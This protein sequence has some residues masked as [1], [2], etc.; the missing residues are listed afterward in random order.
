MDSCAG[1]QK[2]DPIQ[3]LGSLK[4]YL[5]CFSCS[6][7]FFYE[8]IQM[9]M[10][11]AINESL[12]TVFATDASQLS[13]LSSTY[14]WGDLAFLLPAGIILDKYST[15]HTVIYSM[16]LCIISTFGFAMTS[17]FWLA[18]FFHFLTG[19]GNAFCFLACVILVARWFPSNKQAMMIGLV[20]TIAFLGGMTAQ[21]PLTSLAAKFGWRKAL[22]VDGVFGMLVLMQIMMFV[23]DS[24]QSYIYRNN[25]PHHSV[26]QELKQVVRNK[27][28][29][30]AGMYTA[31]LNLP[32]MVLCALWGT[33]ALKA[34]H[35]MT[36]LE[37]S[38]IVSMIFVG[39]IIGCPLAGWLSDNWGY[40]RR[41]MIIGA[42]LSLMVISVLMVDHQM[43]FGSLSVI[44]F[45]LGFF[46][47]TQVVA[48]P[49]IAESNPQ[50]LT[51]TATA[52][53]SIIIMGGAGVAQLLFGELLDLHWQGQLIGGQRFYS[54]SDYHFAMMLFPISF[55]IALVAG[56][57]A[58]ETYCQK[59]NSWSTGK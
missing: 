28:T 58:K 54:T 45:L 56:L 18:A 17:N 51:A 14:L 31:L 27:Q 20:I 13:F 11:N 5:V 36:A 4:A 44:F 19:I 12:R 29:Y 47:S 30:L 9:H 52:L 46:T 23:E 48:Y 57:M 50:Q 42:V 25:Q 55:V 2:S 35:G 38:N 34:L 21:A 3:K 39:S 24:P 16:L 22:W 53:A 26:W 32:I 10:F 59:L 8:F 33:E 15:R 6:M 1:S 37:A 43:S 40:R 7:F 41:P 49:M